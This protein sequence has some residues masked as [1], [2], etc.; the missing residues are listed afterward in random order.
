M[1]NYINISQNINNNYNFKVVNMSFKKGH[2]KPINAFSFKNGNKVN[3]GRKQS[4]ETKQKIGEAS[5][6]NWRNPDYRKK[7]IRWGV[8][9]PFYGE[10]H[11][12]ETKNKI[13]ESKLKNPTRYWLGKKLSK[14]HRLKVSLASK[15]QR[16]SP[17]TEF[18][19]ERTK[20]EKNPN[21][22]GGISS[23]KEIE[24]KSKQWKE[25]RT[26]VYARD[27]YTCQKCNIKGKILHPHHIKYRDTN[28]ELKFDV[29]NGRTLC[30][31]CHR[32][33]HIEE[34]NGGGKN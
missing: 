9:N 19:S 25:W 29:D 22:K 32:K 14:E 6:K 10:K 4:E 13:S 7:I 24:R 12:E 5:K 31:P 15:G 26:K 17:K 33:T 23:E 3:V 21:W 18:T 16:R 1:E 28:P 30:I 8:N 2:L 27:K 34:I 20:G 11:S